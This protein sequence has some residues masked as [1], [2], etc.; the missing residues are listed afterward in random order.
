MERA[1]GIAETSLEISSAGGRATKQK[2]KRKR[3]NAAAIG[4][5]GIAGAYGSPTRQTA[6]ELQKHPQMT[7][8]FATAGL[9]ICYAKGSSIGHAAR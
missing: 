6:N 9:R 4:W 5:K 7:P 3:K 1:F 8:R 2:S